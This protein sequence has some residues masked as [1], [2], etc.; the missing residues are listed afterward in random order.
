MSASSTPTTSSRPPVPRLKFVEKAKIQVEIL[1]SARSPEEGPCSA[2]CCTP[3]TGTTNST[4]E[5]TVD[6]FCEPV[7]PIDLVDN[8]K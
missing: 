3:R 8:K 6:I 5:N 4:S 7:K 2:P 1:C